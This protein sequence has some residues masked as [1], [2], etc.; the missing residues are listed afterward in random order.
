MGLFSRFAISDLAQPCGF[1]GR[2]STGGLA[3]W[4]PG[5]CLGFASTTAQSA[6][7]LRRCRPPRVPTNLAGYGCWSSGHELLGW[8]HIALE[9]EPEHVQVDDDRDVARFLYGEVGYAYDRELEM[10]YEHR[11]GCLVAY[12]RRGTVAYATST[13]FGAGPLALAL[14]LAPRVARWN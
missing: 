5:W 7:E 13:V 4:V 14:Q 2:V 8:R 11:L 9:R 6:F 12:T 1:W 10:V 3:A